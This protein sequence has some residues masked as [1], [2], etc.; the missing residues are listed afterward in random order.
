MVK[1]EGLGETSSPLFSVLK[2]VLM[3]KKVHLGAQVEV[4]E[5]ERADSRRAGVPCSPNLLV[6]R[7]GF[8][9]LVRDLP[10]TLPRGYS[11]RQPK[12]IYGLH[13]LASGAPC[14]AKGTQFIR[15]EVPFTK[16]R[17]GSG[18]LEA[19]GRA[20]WLEASHLRLMQC[21]DVPASQPA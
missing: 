21:P 8:S 11:P 1:G 20:K 7:V 15:R 16:K 17:K 10:L 19:Q 14:Q 2:N 3:E 4:A 18:A 6:T 5:V 12:V 13:K 9:V